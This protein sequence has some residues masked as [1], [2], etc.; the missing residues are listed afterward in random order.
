[1]AYPTK[2]RYIPNKGSSGASAWQEGDYVTAG[3]MNHIEDGIDQAV[4]NAENYADGALNT[5]K[6][7]SGS[8]NPTTATVG[9]V[10]QKYLNTNTKDIY[11]CTNVTGGYT[12]IRQYKWDSTQSKYILM[13]ANGDEIEISSLLQ[14]IDQKADA[15]VLA[16]EYNSQKTYT[17]GDL[18][19]Y[20]SLLYE[21]I[22]NAPVGTLPTNTTYFKAVSVDDVIE[23]IENGNREVATAKQAESIKS[24]RVIENADVSCPP[25]TFGTTGGDAEIQ[26]GYNK[27]KFLYGKSKKW[28]QKIHNGDFD[29][30]NYW[31]ADSTLVTV[32]A[33]NNIATITLNSAVSGSNA[34]LTRIRTTSYYPMSL[35]D[36]GHKFFVS[37]D[38][39]PSSAKTFSYSVARSGGQ[40][41]QDFG[42]PTLTAN[43]WTTIQNIF[44]LSANPSETFGFGLQIFPVGDTA[45]GFI[46]K[47]RNVML[48]D[49]TSIYGAGKEPTVAEFKDEYPLQYYQYNESTI[50]SAKSSELI[51][52]GENQWDE[53][54]ELGSYNSETGA[55]VNNTDTIR[56]KNPIRVIGGETYYL[57]DGGAG[58]IRVCEYDANNN[59]LHYT[60]SPGNEELTLQTNTAFITFWCTSGYGTTYN[61][62]ISIYICWDTPGRPYVANRTDRVTLP[63][64][65]LR[66]VPDYTNGGEIRDEAYQEGG[67]KRYVGVLNLGDL[68]WTYA[69]GR[70]SSR[71]VTDMKTDTPYS[72]LPN[73][74]CPKY[75]SVTT[76][77]A[78][79]NPDKSIYK[80]QNQVGIVDSSYTD[81]N[82]LKTALNGVYLL[83]E[84]ATP[85][86]I[87]T[88]EN[89][90]WTELVYTDNYGTLQFLTNPTQI[91][92]VEQPYYI[93][94]TVS[95]TD[96]LDSVYAHADGDAENL[97]LKES[98]DD[99]VN[100][101]TPAG[102][103][104]LADNLESNNKI[105]DLL[106]YTMR[107]SPSGVGASMLLDHLTGATVAWNQMQV[108]PTSTSDFYANNTTISFSDGIATF[109]AKAANGDINTYPLRITVR[110]SHKYLFMCDIKTSS[111]QVCFYMNYT[112]YYVTETNKW[113]RKSLI[114]QGA[115]TPYFTIQDTRTSGW[116]AVQVKN[117]QIFDLTQMFGST[118][119]NYL[120]NQGSAGVNK[121]RNLFPKPYYPYNAG[122]LVGIKTAG[123]K[124]IGVNIFDQEMELGSI[125][126]G[127]GEK[128]ASST[129]LRNKNNIRVLPNTTYYFTRVT[130]SANI[131]KVYFYDG[132]GS[133]ISY[134]GWINRTTFTT[135]DNCAYI[136]FRL[137]S[138]YGTTYSNDICINISDNTINGTFYP[139]EADEY[140]CEEVELNGLYELDAN[141]NIVAKNGDTYANGGTIGRN[142]LITTVG[143]LSWTYSATAKKFYATLAN[144]KN[145]SS[146]TVGNIIASLY[147]R[148][149]AENLNNDS[150]NMCVASLNGNEVQIKDLAYTDAS[151]FKTARSSV[152]ILVEL[153]T[154][155]EETASSFASTQK[156]GVTEQFMEPETPSTVF[157]PVGHDSFYLP[158]LK[159]KLEDA[160]D[161]PTTDGTYLVSRS[162]G[163]NVYIPIAN[164]TATQAEIDE[165]IAIL[166]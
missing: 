19:I 6:T 90:G 117:F 14:D 1:M 100:G 110:G 7:L 70:F 119:A 52:V 24:N 37:M 8:T 99:I 146:T 47:V 48:I 105:E 114:I 62:D 68:N 118:I 11:V 124:A 116:D 101:N 26:T 132:N 151:T 23:E 51:S 87:S 137:D 22:A 134:V 72:V 166:E 104:L 39:N 86:D 85:T 160:P 140:P 5:V 142:Y 55:K 120:Y 94:Y 107:Q 149:S 103:A 144:I 50:L 54:W 91:P 152:K 156:T 148:A 56:C 88:S 108:A 35:G 153:A 3:N 13:D 31:V 150:Y 93:E 45:S 89:S 92:Q 43:A 121:F 158:D 58:R 46:Y 16:D 40:I 71:A 135:P 28:N 141:N 115:P 80:F 2:D 49:L 106:P 81:P 127:T 33:S 75:T 63:N 122:E 164:V 41:S 154:P 67:G 59:F 112:K 27:F 61:H 17:S 34:Y 78:I 133:F 97:A 147:N 145:V 96:F 66:S 83:Y 109:T 12:W 4:Q 69:S 36:V 161:S 30:L 21:C 42:T 18:L 138:S 73:F 82:T 162:G 111:T 53:D 123:R 25:I 77:Q 9:T 128:T 126:D 32:S 159:E 29:S 57:H 155:T 95:L 163:T 143:D 136:L 165:I 98:V 157:L 113:T 10:G 76:N 125:V 64:I 84:L 129:S 102:K 74:V 130:N 44:T 139:Y 79:N 20:E 65:E 15:T 38:L 60:N 131:A